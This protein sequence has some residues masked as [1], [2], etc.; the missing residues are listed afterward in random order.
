MVRAG[1]FFFLLFVPEV[2]FCQLFEG[3]VI[4]HEDNNSGVAYVNVGIIGKNV[5][6]VTDQSGNFSIYLDKIYDKDSIRFS[7]I[8][9]ESRSFLVRAFKD[10]AIKTIY[11]G[12]KSYSLTEVKIT[13]HKAREVSLGT[14]VISEA[15]KSGFAENNLG[16]E[17]GIKLKTR[18]KVKLEDINLNVSTCTYDSV[19]Y[20]LNIYQTIDEIEYKNI[21]TQPI[22]ISF[23]K[24][25]ID[26]PI[27]LSLG[28]YSIIVEGD[29]LV[30]LELYKDLGQ[31]R[32]LFYTQYF[33]S[34]T[35]HKKTSE[36]K[37][38]KAP[39]AI[40]MYLHGQVIKD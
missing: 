27:T 32:L 23:S 40:G 20:R 36:G 39:G 22:Y 35:Y 2:V 14:P 5:G 7:M 28:K 29:I 6:T 33:T 12:P 31:G 3:R 4:V 16:S 30:T 13:Y 9:Y 17:L 38:T 10:N 21:L 26:K 19:T 34:F 1:F 37:W 15:L 11:L 8:G 25:K 24:D 18:G